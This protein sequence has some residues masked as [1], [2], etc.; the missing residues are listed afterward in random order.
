MELILHRNLKLNFLTKNNYYKDNID[1]F[2][3]INDIFYIKSSK[4]KIFFDFYQ[5]EILNYLDIQA[6]SRYD[7]IWVTNDYRR[8]IMEKYNKNTKNIFELKENKFDKNK[9]IIC[10]TSLNDL[11]IIKNLNYDIMLSENYNKNNL[12][13]INKKLENFSL[14][15]LKDYY[16]VIFLDFKIEYF[17][18]ILINLENKCFIFPKNRYIKTYKYLIDSIEIGDLSFIKN[19]KDIL[20]LK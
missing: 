13:K 10:I 15:K 5:K 20:L 18:Q 16:N 19:F 11:E 12:Y 2:Y 8:K 7:E 6:L 1:I 17:N 14:S 4:I 9:K 3:N